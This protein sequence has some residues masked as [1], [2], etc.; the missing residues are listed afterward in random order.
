MNPTVIFWKPELLITALP[1]GLHVSVRAEAPRPVKPVI[2]VA[3]R[4]N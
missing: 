2:V 3:P 1:T 4:T